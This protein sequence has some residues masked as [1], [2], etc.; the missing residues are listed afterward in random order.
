MSSEPLP[1]STVRRLQERVQQYARST[2][3][4]EEDRVRRNVEIRR[5][6]ALYEVG[7]VELSRITGLG[8]ELV[9]A[10][11]AGRT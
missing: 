2:A 9:R 1:H 5:F 4:A 7:P 6:A 3:Q 8:V 11:L 10:I